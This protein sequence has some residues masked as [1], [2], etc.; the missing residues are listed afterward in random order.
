MRGV[1]YWGIGKSCMR[2]VLT[3]LYTEMERIQRLYKSDKSRFV[4]VGWTCP[5]CQQV[6][7]E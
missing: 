6:K 2:M 3:F 5:D 7:T 1:L 4:P